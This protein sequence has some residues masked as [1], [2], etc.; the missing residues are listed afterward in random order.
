MNESMI[1]G[2]II[3]PFSPAIGKYKLSD[4]KIN[5]LNNHIDEILKDENKIDELYHGKQLAGEIKYEI[6]LT[7][8]FLD[9]NLKDVLYKFVF[10]FVK[11]TLQKEIKKFDLKSSWAVCQFESD[12]NPIHWHTGHPKAFYSTDDY[13]LRV[14]NNKIKNN[15]NTYLL[16]GDSQAMGYGINFDDHFL[17]KY[18]T[19]NKNAHL[20]ILASP[21]FRLQ[22]LNNFK[23][24]N[25]DFNFQK[26]EKIFFFLN[27]WV[28]I[29][30]FVLSWDENWIIKNKKFDIEISKYFRSYEYIKKI[31]NFSQKRK[32]QPYNLY[33][34]FLTD[35]EI[36]YL[37]YAIADQ[38]KLFIDTNS[39][40]Q[41]QFIILPP[42]WYF[43]KNQ[44]KKFNYGFENEEFLNLFND[45]DYYYNKMQNNLE[46]ISKKLKKMGL[47]IF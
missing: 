45:Y 33:F 34:N 26:Y 20:E 27:L 35:D 40:K 31:V 25:D 42:S 37:I 2:Q 10:N 3:R 38:Y 29:D 39:I 13:G 19:F 28:D 36:E 46:I 14:K 1:Q 5:T 7:K 30:R 32:G 18:L 44:L 16:I 22:S 43:D 23:K 4:E 17:H 9:Q 11:S 21:T 15:Q 8:E 12:Y 41:Y 24:V 47:I 6:R